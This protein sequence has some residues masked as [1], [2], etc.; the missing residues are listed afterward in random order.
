MRAIIFFLM[1]TVSQEETSSM[2]LEHSY[3]IRTLLGTGIILIS[4]TKRKKATLA[5]FQTTFLPSL[6]PGPTSQKT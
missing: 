1:L 2:T 5:S 6:C 3:D 4:Q